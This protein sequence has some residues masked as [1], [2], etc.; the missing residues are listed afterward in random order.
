MG[1][2]ERTRVDSSV[3]GTINSPAVLATRQELLR[4]LTHVQAIGRPGDAYGRELRS[5]VMVAAVVVVGEMADLLPELVA[6]AGAGG[7]VAEL[8]DDVVAVGARSSTSSPRQLGDQLVELAGE[9]RGGAV[10]ECRRSE[11]AAAGLRRLELALARSRRD[12]VHPLLVADLFEEDR[13]D[14]AL[15]AD[16]HRAIERHEVLVHYLPTVDLATGAVRGVEALA[17]WQRADEVLDTHE[18]LRLAVE[19]GRI[20]EIGWQVMRQACTEVAA[21][22]ADHPDRPLCLSVNVSLPQL[23]EPGAVEGIV[24]LLE[25]VG[26]DPGQLC[27]EIGE[28]VF[29]L[30]GDAVG[31]TLLALRAAG[32]RLSVDDFGTG[33][34]PLVALQRNPLHELKID[35]SFVAQMDR[36][37]D[38][39][40][41]VRGIARL[42]RSLGLELVAEGVERPA[43]EQMLRSL[44][45]DRA[46]GWLYARPGPGLADVVE[47]ADKAAAASLARQPATHDELWSG[48]ATVSSAAMFVETVFET[49]PIGMALIDD[50]GHH[51]AANPAIGEVIGRS[52]EELLGTTCWEVI[53]PADLAQDLEGMDALLGGEQT[54]YVV[55]ERVIA[56]DGS[57]RWVEV[58]VSGIPGGH[59]AHGHPTR[60]LRQVRSIDADR[61][62]AED[63]AVLSSILSASPD[64]LIITDDKGRCTFWNPAATEL[65]GWTSFEMRGQPLTRL[66]E[67]GEQLAFARLLGDAAA[68]SPV[69]QSDARWQCAEGGVRSVD[70]TVGPILAEDGSLRGLA[71]VARDVTEQRAADL[72]LREAHEALAERARDLSEA[73]DRLGAFAATLSHDLLQPVAALDG[74]LMLL[75]TY[76]P[77]LSD[78]HRDWLHRAIRGK[79]RIAGAISALQK[80]VSF[81][82]VPLARV[83][84][85]EVVDELVADL[86]VEADTVVVEHADLPVVLADRGMLSQIVANLLQNSLRYR[87]HDRPLR[88]TVAARQDGRFWEVSV[89]DTGRG[90][91]AGE[92]EAVF[93]RGVRGE[94]ATGTDGT[95]TGLATVRALARRMGGNA[96]AEAWVD[97][98]RICLRLRGDVPG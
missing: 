9:V 7:I 30:L 68:G 87:V 40:A 74:F 58:T 13:F 26:L 85:G 56:A 88:V 28:E 25:S 65:F 64:A 4:W 66:V 43:Q 2:T 46:Q 83:P 38:A 27:L 3:S 8:R 52:V 97:G 50:K 90:I 95:G 35:R 47:R 48:M 91:H 16:L 21:W 61:T 31:S 70:V 72:A 82:E 11:A 98:A 39:A 34:T 92:L 81:D 57:V 84:L 18:F 32:L 96:W 23:V 53:H 33:S 15:T 60:L 51:L 93:E 10:V 1:L 79:D 86:R 80:N 44:Q 12:P 54:S 63:S 14:A 24:G 75:D 78:E 77:E 89:T 22:N 71:A 36:D 17:R 55:E 19:T 76:A 73:N 6:L 69:R 49:A 59:Q 67:E 94:S 5:G 45:C 41:L 29:S 42:A 37:A 20:V 62:V